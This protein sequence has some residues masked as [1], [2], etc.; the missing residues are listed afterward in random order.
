M[1]PIWGDKD[2]S[3][4]TGVTLCHTNVTLEWLR[5]GTTKMHEMHTFLNILLGT[6]CPIVV[7]TLVIL[8][9]QSTKPLHVKTSLWKGIYF[10]NQ[11]AGEDLCGLQPKTVGTM[12][13]FYLLLCY[14]FVYFPGSEKR[15]L[16][17]P[18]LPK[19]CQNL[20]FSFYGDPCFISELP[21]R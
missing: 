6:F 5:G 8:Q 9:L 2:T 16:Q 19:H 14:L 1:E 10:I 3:I 13:V 21:A 18:A 4:D 15:W 11:V 12:H 7:D 20:K 17:S